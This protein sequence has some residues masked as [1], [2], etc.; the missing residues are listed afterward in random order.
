ML[1]FVNFGFLKKLSENY[2]H[3][4]K[5]SKLNLKVREPKYIEVN[6]RSFRVENSFFEHPCYLF[7]RIFCDPD[8]S[9]WATWLI[10]WEAEFWEKVADPSCL[11]DSFDVLFELVNEALLCMCKFERE[12]VFAFWF[13]RWWLGTMSIFSLGTIFFTSCLLFCSPD[14]SNIRFKQ[15]NGSCETTC[16]RRGFSL[17]ISLNWLAPWFLLK[18]W[19]RSNL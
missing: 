4:T 15:I 12:F 11:V 19:E 2:L 18:F 10:K 14:T 3:I 8:S 6:A 1:S 5:L 13:L 17:R 7:F 16:V 9:R